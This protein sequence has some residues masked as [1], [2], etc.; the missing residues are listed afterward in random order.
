MTMDIANKRE[1]TA[2][3]KSPHH[4]YRRPKPPSEP[5][6]KPIK[7]KYD[8]PLIHELLQYLRDAIGTE[9]DGLFGVNYSACKELIRRCNAK[10]NDPKEVLTTLVD[11]AIKD[12]FHGRNTTSW[13]YL[14]NH[15]VAI[16]RTHQTRFAKPQSKRD[17]AQRK[18]DELF[19]RQQAGF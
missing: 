16:F 17:E 15:A 8:D 9:L 6:P 1:I 12:P 2:P 4:G 11:V 5:K 10:G 19:A 13:R 3:L 7:E 18:A 14:L